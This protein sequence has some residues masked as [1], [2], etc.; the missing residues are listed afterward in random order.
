MSPSA[1]SRSARARRR[2]PGRPRRHPR[3]RDRVTSVLARTVEALLF[4]SAEPVTEAELVAAC[5]CSEEELAEALDELKEVFAPGARGLELRELAG[6]WTLATAA[7]TENAA[8]RLLS[9]PR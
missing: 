6:G 3:R 7:D 5:E 2:R 8:R 4:L 1:R 9:K